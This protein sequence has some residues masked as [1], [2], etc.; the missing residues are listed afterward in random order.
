MAA[1]SNQT[2]SA[3]SLSYNNHNQNQDTWLIGRA[4]AAQPGVLSLIPVATD[5]LIS[6]ISQNI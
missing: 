6:C 1:N 3:L 5:L 4:L 2:A